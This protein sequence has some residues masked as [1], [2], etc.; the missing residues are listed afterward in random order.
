MGLFGHHTR[1][2]GGDPN[3]MAALQNATVEQLRLIAAGRVS[4][5]GQWQGVNWGAEVKNNPGQRAAER[6]AA[7]ALLEGDRT[8]FSEISQGA[9]RQHQDWNGGTLAA[10]APIA[11]G[12]IP[13]VGPLAAMAVGAGM[14]AAT[15]ATGLQRGSVLSGAA[16]GAALGGIG[17]VAQTG[18]SALTSGGGAGAASAAPG[19]AP[20]LVGVGGQMGET[21]LNLA[22]GAPT[23]AAM[24]T[25]WAASAPGLS[26]GVSAAVPSAV[27]GLAAG[28]AKAGTA[29]AGSAIKGAAPSFL[30]GVGRFAAS[31]A[32]LITGLASTA[33]DMYG[34]SQQGAA[35]DA[36]LAMQQQTSDRLNRPWQSF[37]QWQAERRAR[38]ARISANTP[39]GTPTSAMY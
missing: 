39:G 25:N 18:I 12:F 26:A 11:A 31:A 29:V 5:L 8:R 2:K 10:L 13:G 16:Q 22:A 17:K 34:A 7:Q 32:P 3:V 23:S 24:P 36:A 33:A 38:Q 27:P 14:G 9:D 15:H 20:D 30:G 19:A 4:D 21:P 28:T 1:N 35:E 6:A 37:D